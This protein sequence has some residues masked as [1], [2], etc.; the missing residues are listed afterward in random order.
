VPFVR[1]SRD[2]RG[3][4]HV[5]LVHTT[6]QR[7]KASPARIMYWYRTPPG[8]KVGREP[9]DETARRALE[10]EYPN[11]VFD[12][13]RIVST[14]M[15]APETENWRERRR[16]ERAMRQARAADEADDESS[17]PADAPAADAVAVQRTPPDAPEG[18]RSLVESSADATARGLTEHDATE[19]EGMDQGVT[20]A[21]PTAAGQTAPGLIG[22]G[23]RRRRRG[24]RRRRRPDTADNAAGTAPASSDSFSADPGGADTLDPHDKE[25]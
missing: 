11:V 17:M 2:K 8:V 13:K 9:F 1:F 20:A 7:G 22:E 23:R 15:P 24:G 10:A 4:E 16:T 5:Y 14:Q 18:V 21:G 6:N 19:R 12:W 3:Y 25:E